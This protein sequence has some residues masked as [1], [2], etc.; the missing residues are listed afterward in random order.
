VRILKAREQ[1]A[2]DPAAS[3]TDVAFQVGFADL[4]YFERSFRRIVGQS[5]REFRRA[6]HR[7]APLATLSSFLSESASDPAE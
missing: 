6:A 3:V 5:P 4:S 1:L 7:V 2:A